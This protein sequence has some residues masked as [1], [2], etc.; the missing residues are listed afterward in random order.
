MKIFGIGMFKT[1]TKSLGEALSILGY[2][3]NANF[4]AAVDNNW[5]PSEE[6]YSDSL[7]EIYERATEYDAF[8][9]APWMFVY[10][11]LDKEFPHSKFILTTRDYEG[12]ATS[13][14]K[15]WKRSGASISEVPSRHR[16]IERIRNHDRYVREY[17]EGR[18]EDLLNLNICEGE[19]WEKLCPFLGVEETPSHLFP[20]ENKGE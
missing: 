3:T 1:G 11:E 4:W 16:F 5:Y 2:R 12:L 15:M 7:L 19:G 13:E 20:Y 8:C 6:E 14:Y 18:D 9:D 10:K 17:F